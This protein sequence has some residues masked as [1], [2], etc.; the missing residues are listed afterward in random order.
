MKKLRSFVWLSCF[1][2]SAQGA[3]NEDAGLGGYDFL[4]LGAGAQPN[5]MAG[6]YAG[7]SG[8]I[9]SLYWNPAGVA[10]ITRTVLM[11]DYTKYVLDMHRGMLA[12]VLDKKRVKNVGVVGAYLNYFYGG[13]FEAVDREGNRLPED[14]FSAGYTEIGATY[15]RAL[16]EFFPGYAL[17]AGFTVKT[18]FERISDYRTF[19]MGTDLGLHGAFPSSRFKLGLV[20]KNLG[21]V[22][23]EE[24]MEV[25]LPRTYILGLQYYAQSQ[26]RFT[27]DWNKPQFGNYSVRLG[28]EY[29]VNRDFCVRGGYRFLQDELEHWVHVLR[30]IADDYT[31]EDFNTWSAGVGLRLSKSGL[32]DISAAGTSYQTFP[33]ISTT[34]IYTFK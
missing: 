6:A 26:T 33:L 8:D 7:S 30:N 18:L 20:V 21:K 13:A 3:I 10:S 27:L 23:G 11:A 4:N 22:F 16:P 14:D 34:L 24:G 29:R 12:G 32:L 1:I 25:P 19:S 2:L 9:H 15:A 31:R 17:S 28:M 5:A